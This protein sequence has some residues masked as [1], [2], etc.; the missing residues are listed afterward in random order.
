MTE[1]ISPTIQPETV[2]RDGFW[3]IDEVAQYL[4]VTPHTIRKWVKTLGFPA[5]RVGPMRVL[6]RPTEVDAWIAK[7]NETS[8][9]K[10]ANA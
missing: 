3:E 8:D 2:A 10:A 1:E 5:T 4:K 6:F 7:Q 9:Q